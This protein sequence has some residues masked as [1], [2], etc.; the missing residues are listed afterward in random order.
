MSTLP[1]L[2]QRLRRVYRYFLQPLAAWWITM[3]SM[4]VVAMTEPM[5][6]ALL[7]PLLD[8]GFQQSRLEIWQVPAALLALFGVRGLAVFAGQV[9]LAKVANQG[10]LRL[11][12]AMFQR[13]QDA[14]LSLFREQTASALGNTL[15]YE[16][17]NGAYLM[18][19]ALLTLGR[20]SMTLL[21][22][23]GYLLYLNWKLT[24]IVAFLFPAVAWLMKAVSRRLY[25]LTQRNQKSTDELAYVVE[26]TALAHRE[27]RLHGAQQ[28]Q[29]ERFRHLAVTLEQIGM[30]LTVAGS[31]LTPL[32]QMMAAMALS[33]VISVAL[34]QSQESGMTVGSFAAFVTAMLM[35]IAPIKHLSEITGPISRGLAALER[36]VDLIESTAIEQQGAHSAPSRVDDHHSKGHIVLRQVS[37]TYPGASAPALGGIDLEIRPGETVALVGASGSGKTTLANLLPR[38]VDPSQGSITLDGIE[39][40]DWQLDSLRRHFAMVSQHVVVMNDTLANNVSLGAPPER[41]RVLECLRAAHLGDYVNQLPQHLDTVVGHN[42]SQMSGGERQRLAIARALYRDA[43]VLILDEATSALDN[44]SERAV[45]EALKILTR[46]RT[47]LVIAHRLSTVEHADR[48]VVMEGGR[49]IEQGQHHELLQ[50]QG[51]YAAMF[52]LNVLGT[53]PTDQS[54]TGPT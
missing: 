39:L 8:S 43:P 16:V 30:K 4:V 12:V 24:L 18:V 50:Q 37:V 3:A 23:V 22:L 7:K 48:I 21:A 14:E 6:P 29:V 49:I 46:N 44:E 33:A 53:Q 41:Q 27:I 52:K 17:Q 19:H 34:L 36:A 15:I 38:F 1:D 2:S 40:R 25:G 51:A 5:I 13:L 45:Q 35:L 32:T 26:E 42:A 54:G 11:R 9:C 10:L 20:D 31:A 47:T 28:P